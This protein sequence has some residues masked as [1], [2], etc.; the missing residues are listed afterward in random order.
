MEAVIAQQY[1]L[2][3]KSGHDLK[4]ARS[5]LNKEIRRGREMQAVYW[6]TEIHE[7]GFTNYL[8]YSLAVIAS[9][10]IGWQ[11]PEMSAAIDAKLA[12]WKLIYNE[13]K[14]KAEYTPT[15]GAV[16]LMMCRSVK[17]RSGDNFWQLC[18][19]RRK[20]GWRLEIPAYAFD[21]HVELGRNMGRFYRFW[22]AQAS[23]I[24]PRAKPEEIG[25]PDY[26]REIE[27]IWLAAPRQN[28]GHSEST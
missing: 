17:T 24:F 19:E 2:K 10:D 15:L 16:I 4:L 12:L 22:V 26:Q 7:A 18:K 20:Q 25:G 23:K 9:E 8:I 5:A 21:E 1:E 3:T 14:A 28:S 11:S 6:A 13:K 27:D